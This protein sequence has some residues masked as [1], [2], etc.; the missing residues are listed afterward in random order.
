MYYYNNYYNEKNGKS[1]Q[2]LVPRDNTCSF[3]QVP[4]ARERKMLGLCVV[5][6]MLI[7]PSCLGLRAHKSYDRDFTRSYDP[8]ATTNDTVF[9]LE[10][11]SKIENFRDECMGYTSFESCGHPLRVF[12]SSSGVYSVRNATVYCDFED[13]REWMVIFRRDRDS[14]PLS[15]AYYLFSQTYDSYAEGLGNANSHHW[16]G[17]DFV[18]KFTRD[19][20]SR[21]RI[22]LWNDPRNKMLIDYDHFYLDS[23]ENG[24]RLSVDGYSGSLLDQL[25]YHNGSVFSTYDHDRS[26]YSCAEM[27]LGGWWYKKC[28]TAL[29]TGATVTDVYWGTH[30]FNGATMK[31]RPK[32]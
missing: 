20:P 21:L 31:I 30:T 23:P 5:C 7:F 4:I 27:F 6:L 32:D 1:P 29:F 8:N 24:Y 11:K 13:N 12:S 15:H 9:F 3:L 16:L 18:H 28:W 19:Y 22:E 14:L 26:H 17:L 10:A 25:S 2:V